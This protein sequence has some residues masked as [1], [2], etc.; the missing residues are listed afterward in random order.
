MKKI[1]IASILAAGLIGAVQAQ[2]TTGNLTASGQV[3]NAA[4]T[5]GECPLLSQAVNVQISNGVQATWQCNVATATIVGGACSQNGSTRPNSVTCAY[6]MPGDPAQTNMTKND[7]NCP[8]VAVAGTPP[9]PLPTVQ[10]TGRVAFA[11]TSQGGQVAR[12]PLGANVTCTANDIR[13][14]AIFTDND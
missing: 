8:D 11:G 10:Y 12:N 14:L 7:P 1:V 3:G 4:N 9:D 5:A 2:V 13:T 6:S